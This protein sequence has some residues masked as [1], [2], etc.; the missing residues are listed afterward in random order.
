MRRVVIG[1]QLIR[2]SDGK[3]GTAVDIASAAQPDTISG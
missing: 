1:A 3:C 2:L